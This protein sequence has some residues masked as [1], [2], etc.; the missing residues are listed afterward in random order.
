MALCVRQAAGI[1]DLQEE[2]KDFWM[3]FLQFIQQD[4]AMRAAAQL[5][6]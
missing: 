1:K 6:S 4:D 2:I 5:T 3:S